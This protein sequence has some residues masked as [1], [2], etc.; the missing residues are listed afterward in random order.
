MNSK[1]YK[2]EIEKP[3]IFGYKKPPPELQAKKEV[4]ILCQT[5]TIRGSVHV[6]R[7]GAGEH[8][9]SHKSVDGF[10]MVLTGSVAFYGEGDTFY[11]EFGPGEGILMPRNNRYWFESV[12]DDDA[13][14]VQVLHFD[15]G[16]VFD[17][18]DHEEAKFDRAEIKVLV[19]RKQM[20]KPST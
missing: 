3:Q 8:L 10:W 14:I 7:G 9:H 17:R 13:E 18:E 6:V 11:G 19:G 12:G 16:K 4:V 2:S 5:P 15:K 1:K 20:P